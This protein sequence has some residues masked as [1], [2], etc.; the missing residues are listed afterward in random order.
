MPDGA[1][2]AVDAGVTATLRLSGA[3]VVVALA[4]G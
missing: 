1:T 3:I 4:P 2:D